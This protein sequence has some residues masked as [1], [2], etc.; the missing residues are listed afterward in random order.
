VENVVTVMGKNT[1]NE[2]EATAAS[3]NNITSIGSSIFF[4]ASAVASLH[5]TK[6]EM[7]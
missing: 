3:G 6:E 5:Q 4:K 2:I 1:F 7:V